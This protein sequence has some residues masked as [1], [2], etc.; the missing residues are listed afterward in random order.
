MRESRDIVV[1]YDGSAE[2]A[3]AVL[4][5]V[6][7][8]VLRN[9]RLH[10]V[11]CHL[12]PTPSQDPAVGGGTTTD[13]VDPSPEAILAEGVALVKAVAPALDVQASLIYGW[14]AVHL[15]RISQ[16]Q[17]LLVVGSRG[18]GGF[19]GLLVGSV[20]LELA[21]TSNCPVAVIRRADQHPAG[22]VV[23]A[24]D[25]SG[26]AAALADACAM[27][28][29]T[30][31]PLNVLHV[32][33]DK[34]GLALIRRRGSKVPVDVLEAAVA[35]ARNL[36]PGISIEGKLLTEKSTARA[37]LNAS[38]DASLIVMGTTGRGLVKGVIGSTTHAVLHH[39]RGPVLVSRRT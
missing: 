5:A 23:V 26:S 34:N 15:S 21:A 3:Q 2:A 38:Q 35:T 17:E 13:D 29:L 24:V 22:A 28:V 32:R 1:G 6:T 8:S 11:H 25:A 7:Q 18:F 20:S 27:A 33:P 31:S 14:P 16:G 30:G 10:L 12:R 9:C 19:L 4:W 39:A 36:A 37:I